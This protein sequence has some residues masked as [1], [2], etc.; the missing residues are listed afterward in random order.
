MQVHRLIRATRV[1]GA[2]TLAL[3][4]LAVPAG[5]RTADNVTPQTTAHSVEAPWARALRIR[6]EAMNQ[7]YHLGHATS[8]DHDPG[9]APGV[10]HV[11]QPARQVARPRHR[12]GPALTLPNTRPPR[13]ATSGA[14]TVHLGRKPK[15]APCCFRRKRASPLPLSRR[16]LRTRGECPRQRRHHASFRLEAVARPPHR[17]SARSAVVRRGLRPVEPSVG[18]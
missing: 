2:S 12:S 1:L 11:H 16:L 3:L 9:A 4:V 10:D 6:S 7:R 17:A 8:H 13:L 18:G 14:G 15:S 5:A